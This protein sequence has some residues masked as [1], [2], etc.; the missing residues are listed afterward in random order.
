MRTHIEHRLGAAGLSQAKCK[1]PCGDHLGMRP[2][3]IESTR[4]A[5]PSHKTWGSYG[6]PNIFIQR[7]KV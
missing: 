3:G 2:R 5:L 1:Q 4:W 7:P 6:H